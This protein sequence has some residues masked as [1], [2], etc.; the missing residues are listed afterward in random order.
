MNKKSSSFL[1]FLFFIG[2]LNCKCISVNQLD[3]NGYYG[4][5]SY[6]QPEN[7]K[8]HYATTFLLKIDKSKIKLYGTVTTWGREY[9]YT[10]N[11]TKDTIILE[12]SFKIYRKSNCDSIIYFETY[13]DNKIEK[14][15]FQKFSNIENVID[16]KGINIKGLTDF[17][18]KNFIVGKYKYK[19]KYI[20]FN[21]NGTVENLKN[22]SKYSIKPRIGTS[23]NYDDCIIETDRGIWK[24]RKENGN[25]ILIKYSSKRDEYDMYILSEE[26]I[27]LEKITSP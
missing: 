7:F 24:Y 2:L 3:L 15:E 6:F 18:N 9:S 13:I 1:I 5:S 17:L 14:T 22:F 8:S 21:E 27:E 23:T 12:N 25:L 11:N 26:K 16:E 20:Y 19:N 10:F 4:M